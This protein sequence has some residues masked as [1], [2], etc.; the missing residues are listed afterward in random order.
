MGIE[1]L[2][3]IPGSDWFF[4]DGSSVEREKKIAEIHNLWLLT[5]ELLPPGELSKEMAIMEKS[6][7]ALPRATDSEIEIFRELLQ[8][9]Y[10]R[11][12]SGV[13]S[14][15]LGSDKTGKGESYIEEDVLRDRVLRLESV[16]SRVVVGQPE[17]VEGVCTALTVRLAGLDEPDKPMARLLFVGPTGVGK[18]ELAKAVAREF[19]GD[20]E[21][22]LSINVPEYKN[23]GDISRLIGAA[24][25]Y[26]GHD[27]GGLLTGFVRKKPYSVILVD[28]VEKGTRAVTDLFLKILDEGQLDDAQGKRVDFTNTIII[29]TSNAGAAENRV[30]A[31][32]KEQFRPEFLG[33]LNGVI[34]FHPLSK[35][36]VRQIVDLELDKVAKRGESKGKSVIFS[37]E[38][39]E[40]LYDTTFMQSTGKGAREVRSLLFQTVISPLSK[41]I[42]VSRAS[43]YTVDRQEGRI[44]IAA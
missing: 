3:P 18:T 30:A 20:P 43:R 28:E 15:F 13:V 7:G 27:E 32:V 37:P 16:L 34:E 11:L 25:G 36:M 5:K 41:E 22:I 35:E 23:S 1:R 12:R 10:D 44:V 29:F 21:A 42:L 6:L 14:K 40:Y 38:L 24:P 2:A 33:R 26:V 17:A 9:N 19:F 39:R 8:N 4:W 31:A